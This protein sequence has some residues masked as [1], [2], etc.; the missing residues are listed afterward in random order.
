MLP[1]AL[2]QR[3]MR[4]FNYGKIVTRA[5]G[6][7]RCIIQIIAD[8][9]CPH[10]VVIGAVGTIMNSLWNCGISILNAIIF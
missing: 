8:L 7:S 6:L 4:W 1:W 9:I 5:V 10:F 3:P 2:L